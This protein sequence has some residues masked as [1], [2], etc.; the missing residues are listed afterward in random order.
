[1]SGVLARNRGESKVAYQDTARKIEVEIIRLMGSEK[2]VPKSYRFTIALPTVRHA[3]RL[4]EEVRHG[5]DFYPTDERRLWER[6]RHW[7]EAVGCCDDI[8]DD[9][10]LI[11]ELGLSPDTNRFERIILLIEKEKTQLRNALRAAHVVGSKL[12]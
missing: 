4:M 11:R 9:L 12:G 2:I 6:K 7:L 5:V 8:V 1:M 10:Q 3:R